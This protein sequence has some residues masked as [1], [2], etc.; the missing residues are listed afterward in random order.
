MNKKYVTSLIPSER[1]R[2]Q[3]TVNDKTVSATIRKRAAILLLADERAGKPM[4]QEEI[5]VRCGVTIFYTLKDYCT[6]G[7]G[8]T[9]EF[10]RTKATNPP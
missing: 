9:L 10:K 8:Y 7:L 2:I 1:K 5:S 3:D 6:H 4:K